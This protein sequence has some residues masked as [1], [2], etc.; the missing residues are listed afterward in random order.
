MPGTSATATR[1]GPRPSRSSSPRSRAVVQPAP[2]ATSARV[3]PYTW[4]MP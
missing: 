4:G 1:A 2:K 3:L